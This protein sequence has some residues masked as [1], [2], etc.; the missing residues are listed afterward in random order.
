MKSTFSHLIRQ[1]KFQ[2]K[3][4][5]FSNASLKECQP[6]NDQIKHKKSQKN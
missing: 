6:F 1:I 4:S 3:F 2:I 5:D